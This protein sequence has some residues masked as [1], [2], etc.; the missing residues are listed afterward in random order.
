MQKFLFLF[1]LAVGLAAGQPLFAQSVIQASGVPE[2]IKEDFEQRFNGATKVTWMKDS[3][4]YYG[5]R[6]KFADKRVQTVYSA[7]DGKWIQTVEPVEYEE[8]PDSA[9]FYVEGNYP[10]YNTHDP[11][12]VSTRSYGILFEVNLKKDLK[13]V[14]LAF[15]MHGNLVRED[16]VVYEPGAAPEHAEEKEKPKG[17]KAKLQKLKR[18]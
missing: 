8:F 6:F 1:L 5:A 4:D 17:L 10:K 15:D 11:K 12:K 16:K 18:Q 2:E 14:E 3:P 13:G 7:I 9:R